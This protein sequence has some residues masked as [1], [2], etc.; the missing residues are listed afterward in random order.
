MLPF[1][2]NSLL[3]AQKLSRYTLNYLINIRFTFRTSYFSFISPKHDLRLPKNTFLFIFS[4]K[5]SNLFLIA[6]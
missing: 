1:I 2:S 6:E 5:L 3:C 4:R